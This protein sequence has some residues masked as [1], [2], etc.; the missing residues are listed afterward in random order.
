MGAITVNSQLTMMELAKRIAPDNTIAPV[1]EVLVRSNEWMEDAVWVEAN[2]IASHSVTRRTKLPSGTYRKLNQGVASETSQ[3]EQVTEPMAILET[4]AEYDKLMVDM[5]PNPKQFRNMEAQAFLEGLGQT[6]SATFIYGAIAT[7]PAQFDGLATRM[8][9]L[10]SLNVVGCSGTGSDVSSAYI[11]Q[12]G[13]NT[14]HMIYP[15][16]SKTV[17][18]MHED[19]GVET[20]VDSS[21]NKLRVYRDQFRINCG[22]VVRDPRCIARVANAET[23]GSSNVLTG[24]KLIEVLNRMPQGGKGAVIYCNPTLYTQ[25]DQEAVNKTNVTYMSDEVWGRPIMMFRGIPVKRIE[26]ILNTET[27]IS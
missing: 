16:G 20:N 19:L 15:R 6:L 24:A 25:L 8:G 13:P 3:T 11:V 2:D 4:F 7:A 26:A 9:T 1:A 10:N 21:G 17:G 27:A 14:V 5:A 18:I 12:W 23:S 22:L